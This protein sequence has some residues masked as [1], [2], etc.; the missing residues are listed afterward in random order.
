MFSIRI[1]P[2]IR[3]FTNLSQEAVIEKFNSIIDS[4]KYPFQA[5]F[6][7]EHI[8]VRC[9]PDKTSIWSPEL[10]LDVV[11]N[12]M[13]DDDYTEHKEETLVRG[14][15]SPNPSIWA[16]FIFSYVGFGLMFLGFLVYG[17]SQMMLDQPTQMGWYALISLVLILAVFM[18]SQ[19]GQRLGE[20]QTN[21]FLKFVEEGIL[22]KDT[23]G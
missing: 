9:K 8:F 6:V 14:Y 10:T 11:E 21:M 16:L 22:A 17:T 23:T 18:A 15:V 7:E 2:R 3:E 13:K 20:E 19:I 1:R 4:N 12:Y 5:K